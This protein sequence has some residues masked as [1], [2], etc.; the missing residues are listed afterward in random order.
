MEAVDG[1]FVG[2]G[3]IVGA[4][5]VFQPAVLR[6]HA[7]VIET[8]R[9]GM[10]THDLAVFV[11]HQV[12][13]VAVQY[14]RNAF[15]QRCSVVVAVQPQTTGFNA[16]HGH[17]RVFDV[18]VE[19]T[20]GVRATTDTGNNRIW[21]TANLLFTLALGFATND[22][23][24]VT[25]QHWVRVRTGR[26]T[27][28]VEGVVNVGY[29]VTHRL[30]HGVFQGRC[31]GRNRVHFGTQQL[32]AVHVQLLTLNVGRTH[33][34]LAF[35]TK[36]GRYGGRCHAVLTST[37]FSNDFLF[38]HKLGQQRLTNGVVHLVGTGVVQVFTLQE[39]A[40]ATTVVA[41]TLGIVQ[42]RRTADVVCQVVVERFLEVCIV[43]QLHVGCLQ[44]VQSSCQG[45]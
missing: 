27:N 2:S 10:G 17:F 3:N 34:D 7:R 33:E 9:D 4:T 42:R 36:T 35:Q 41:Q 5:N 43:T 8:G 32:H 30:V 23:L 12:G 19:H 25:Y 28:D 1:F 31:T 21:L 39:D 13:T 24:E 20:N 38:A 37:G 15:V 18:W 45:F 44:L 26:G 14:A 6:T 22:A 40:R 29:P 16:V 11:F